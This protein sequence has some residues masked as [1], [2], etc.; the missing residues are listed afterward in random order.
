[1]SESFH[2][3]CGGAGNLRSQCFRSPC[4]RAG[5]FS[6]PAQRKVTKRKRVAWHPRRVYTAN[7]HC[8]DA[9]GPI[10][11]RQKTRR[12]Q[13]IHSIEKPGVSVSVFVDENVNAICA[14]FPR[15]RAAPLK[16]PR[17]V[18]SF[19]VTF[20]FARALRRRSGANGAA[21]PEGAEGRMP[22]VKKEVTR[23][24]AGEWKPW[25]WKLPARSQESERL[26]SERSYRDKSIE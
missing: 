7:L 20:F 26:S 18:L 3:S 5:N 4:R 22:G 23:S 8:R 25:L 13:A 16:A 24:S 14:A 6:L 21:G 19:L 10:G 12:R 11:R 9:P 17:T 1:M 15:L 2:S